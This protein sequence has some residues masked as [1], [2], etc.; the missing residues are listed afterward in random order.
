MIH[1]IDVLYL[2]TM[3]DYNS[4]TTVIICIVFDLSFMNIFF[5]YI[6]GLVPKP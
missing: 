4:I 2:L 6:S 1:F 5:S 3:F